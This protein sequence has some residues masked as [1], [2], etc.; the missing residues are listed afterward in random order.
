M[1]ASLLSF[2]DLMHATNRRT[3]RMIFETCFVGLQAGPIEFSHGVTLHATD[4]VDSSLL[5]AILVPGFW[6]EFA[7]HVEKALVTHADLV[8]R[9]SVRSSCCH[10]WSYCTGVCLLAASGHLSD[11]P[12]TVTW[13]LAKAMLSVT[14]RCAG[15]VSITV[16][17]MNELPP[18]RV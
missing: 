16:F 7:L 18:L 1:P 13:W 12:A 10:L 17:S 9:L 11:Q 4:T 6:S 3:G 14:I 2:A 15:R 8:R 5:D